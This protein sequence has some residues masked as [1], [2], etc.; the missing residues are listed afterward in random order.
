MALTP[1]TRLGPYE[2]VA[3]IGAG[4]MGEVYRARDTRLERT[5]A[6]KVLPATL[7]ANP[8]LKQRFEREARAISALQHPHI[9]VLHD[10]GHHDGTDFLVME[11]LEGETLSE[12]LKRGPLPLEQ[13]WKIAIEV[14]DALDKA[15]RAGIVH[16]DLKP[17][18][19]MLT[20]AGAKLLDFGLAK[21]A[22]DGL[23]A[24]AGTSPSQSV[25]SAAMT[26]SSPASPLTSAGAIVG[27]VQYMAP[28]QIE[29]KDADARSDIFSFGLVLYEMLTGARA[30][31]GKTQASVVAAILALEPKPLRSLNPDVP[32]S[33]ER[34][35]QHC[36][37]KD[38]AERFQNAHDLKLQMQ[39]IAE[40]P[41]DGAAAAAPLPATRRWVSWAVAAVLAVAVIMLAVAYVQTL[42]APQTSLHAYILPPPKSEFNLLANWS[43]GVAISRDGRRIAFV[44]KDPDNDEEMLWVQSLDSNT[45]RPMPGTENAGFPFWSY[46]GHYVGFFA[47][48]KLQKIA[49][50]GGPPQTICDAKD[51]RG[52]DWNQDNV[53]L[54]TP[55]PGDG[56]FRVPAAGGT[57]TQVTELEARAGETSHRWPMFLPDGKHYLF[58]IQGAKVAED[59]GIYVGALDSKQRRLL[60]PSESSGA[61][62]EPGY[63]LFVRDG[64]LLAQKLN[65]G[66]LQLEGDARPVAAH[67]GVNTT[68]FRSI[69]AASATGTLLYLEGG[70]SVGH[71]LMWY[72]LDGKP[73]PDAVPEEAR[74]RNPAF[75]PD[76][77]RLAASIVT[78]NSQDIWV[79]DLQR[80]SKSRLTFAQGRSFH[81]TWSP[82]GRWIYYS[83]FRDGRVYM[84]RRPSDGTGNEETILAPKGVRVA[85]PNSISN[86]GKYVA[87]QQVVDSE[88]S[89]RNYDLYVLPLFGDRKPIPQLLSPFLKAWPEFSPDGKWLAYASE[90]T[91]RLEVYAMPFPGPGGKYQLS[92]GG[93][94]NPKWSRDG[95]ELFFSNDVGEV[96][97]VD[98]RQNGAALQLGTPRKVLKASMVGG[99][100]G[101]FAVSPDGKKV[102]INEI[103][104]DTVHLPLTVVTN[105]TAE[106]EH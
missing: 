65:L 6:I 67:V 16:R 18:N 63:L 50:E 37:E 45:A 3:P 61:Y 27:T 74:Y 62:A 46:D 29:G 34:M 30:F 84:Y 71:R 99:P 87:Y 5:V 17:A 100:E 66:K 55:T 78:S 19:V 48:G 10:V 2:I 47:G 69:F 36:L 104:N 79:F 33:L 58:W 80:K 13:F 52:G 93:G 82:D 81:P 85:I 90:E 44:A 14:A 53:V 12:R 26:R 57:P 15:H 97:A 64:A 43:G 49:A 22:G 31:E 98:V 77:N 56:L 1:G 38:P 42:R 9:C 83:S 60:V 4:G 103:G 76:G 75:S 106:L 102:L 40:M 11:Y 20:K 89:P 91:G 35:V 51:A 86:D 70:T 41:A 21:T 95:R 105:W 72:G 25:F 23:A 88:K 59:G 94:N 68:V 8:E 39:L 24:A 101:P 92:T 28:E 96:L 73:G 7:N 32:Q 54:F